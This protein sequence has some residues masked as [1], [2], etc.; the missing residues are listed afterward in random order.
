MG[1]AAVLLFGVSANKLWSITQELL[2]TRINVNG[3]SSA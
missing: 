1:A 2:S 3:R